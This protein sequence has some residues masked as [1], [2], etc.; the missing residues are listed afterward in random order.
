MFFRRQI[1]SFFRGSASPLS[2]VVVAFGI[3][4][5]RRASWPTRLPTQLCYGKIPPPNRCS[6]EEPLQ[7]RKTK[8]TVAFKGTK[9]VHVKTQKTDFDRRFCTFQ[10][11][12]RAHHPQTMPLLSSIHFRWLP[13]F[14]CGGFFYF[15]Q[16][17]SCCKRDR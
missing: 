13:L 15:Y 5:E 14:F 7:D 9:R 3:E 2:R 1:A 8:R 11:T 4:D 10:V 17:F 12:V 6:S 16:L